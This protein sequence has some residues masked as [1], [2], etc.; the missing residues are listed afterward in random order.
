MPV[1]ACAV[2]DDDGLDDGGG[3]TVADSGTG[4]A[5]AWLAAAHVPAVYSSATRR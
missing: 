1:G 4:V 5:G 2:S 3:R